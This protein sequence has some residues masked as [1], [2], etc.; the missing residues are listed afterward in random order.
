M[1]RWTHRRSVIGGARPSLGST[2]AL[3]AFL[4]QRLEFAIRAI[5]SLPIGVRSSSTTFGCGS[6]DLDGPAFD[7]API[8]GFNRGFGFGGIGHHDGGHRL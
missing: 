2:T 6:F 7:L 5:A 8:Q 1:G 3:T 4:L